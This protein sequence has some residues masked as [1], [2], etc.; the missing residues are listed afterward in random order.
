[1]SAAHAFDLAAQR[2]A[3]W[4]MLGF[5]LAVQLPFARLSAVFDYPDVLR[6]PAGQV[7]QAFAAGGDALA[8]TWYAYAVSIGLFAAAVMAFGR[9]APGRSLVTALGLASAL[10]QSAALSRWVFAVPQLARLHAVADPVLQA[11]IEVQF[12][13]LN[14]YVG[15]GLGEHLGQILMVAWTL[16][17]RR[18]LA[19]E[20]GTRQILPLAASAL[21]ALGL[22]EQ[23]LTALGRDGSALA[24]LSTLGFL[25][26]SLWLLLLGLRWVRARPTLQPATANPAST[27]QP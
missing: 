7:L 23:L 14:H 6:Q 5:V 27:P 1:M 12:S 25:L 18:L 11:A 9:A 22:I 15:T 3:G 13:V 26:W 8:L 2:R 24:P 4:L 21:L 20:H 17:M 19:G 10:L 16:G